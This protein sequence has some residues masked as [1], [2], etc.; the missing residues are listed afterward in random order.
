MAPKRK[1]RAST[2][3]EPAE[4]V[5]ISLLDSDDDDEV[6]ETK[7]GRKSGRLEKKRR[8]LDSEILI[9]YPPPVDGKEVKGSITLTYGDL[10][11]LRPHDPYLLANQLLLNDSLVDYY[12]QLLIREKLKEEVRGRVHIFN[13]FFLKRLRNSIVGKVDPDLVKLMKWVQV[14]AMHLNSR[15][16][17]T[18]PASRALS[19][20]LR[21]LPSPCTHPARST[22]T[23][24]RRISFSCPSTRPEWAATGRSPSSA[25]RS[26]S[27]ALRRTA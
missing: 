16:A 20:G 17:L 4:H 15:P 2:S 6:V 5:T 27:R 25:R 23:S 14:A 11:R 9:V 24:S 8:K 22:S 1:A 21:R 26:S 12:V 18:L 7:S 19:R 3:S 13:S 10:R